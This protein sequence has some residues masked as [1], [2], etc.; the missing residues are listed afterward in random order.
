MIRRK[1]ETMSLAKLTLI[2]FYNYD[3][4][5]FQQLTVPAGIDRQTLIDN[6]LLRGGEF[7]CLYGSLPFIKD[8]IGVWSRKWQDTFTRWEEALETE[9]KPLENYDRIEEWDD[10]NTGTQTMVG[11]GSEKTVK[12][13]SVKDE[14]SGTDTTENFASA[15]DSSTY[16]P[17]SKTEVKPASANTTTYNNTTDTHTLDGLTNERT[18]DLAS[19]HS[20]RTH[21]NIGVTT[22]QQMLESEMMLR[23]KWNIYEHITDLFLSEFVLPVY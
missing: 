10:T 21:G 2:G 11:T 17:T 6:I 13:G 5:L 18:D 20:G 8:A 14:G 9:Y 16:T 22:S 1:E 7:E 23:L 12:T 3:H 4:N 19:H 15:Y